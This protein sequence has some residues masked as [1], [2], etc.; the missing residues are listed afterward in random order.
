MI[1]S[2]GDNYITLF[3]VA[4]YYLPLVLVDEIL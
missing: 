1:K 4:T 3:Q 2:T